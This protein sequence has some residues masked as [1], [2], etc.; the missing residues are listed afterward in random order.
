MLRLVIRGA[1]LSVV[2]LPLI[3]CEGEVR[4]VEVRHPLSAPNG[5]NDPR[6]SQ[7]EEN[8]YQISQG[9]RYALWYGCE[10]CHGP[11]ASGAMDL[12]DENWQHGS[13]F[14]EIHA[15][16]ADGHVSSIPRYDAHIPEEQL[17]QLTA[18]VRNLKNIGVEKRR[19]EGFDQVREPRLSP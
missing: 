18:Y 16:I 19:R 6:I 1:I 3:G 5:P 8:A 15:F 4:P 2:F 14:H 13:G 9:G 10:V 7:Y 11:N 12:M 17:W